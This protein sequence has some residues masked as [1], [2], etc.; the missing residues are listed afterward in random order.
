MCGIVGLFAKTPEVEANLGALLA[1]M[2]HE[3]SD[4]GPDSAGVAFYRNPV[5]AGQTKLTLQHDDSDFD[6][7]VLRSGLQDAMGAEQAVERRGNHA[8]VIAHADL[9][10]VTSFEAVLTDGSDPVAVVVP[11]HRDDGT[12]VLSLPTAATFGFAIAVQNIV[13]GLSQPFIGALADRY[14]A[15]RVSLSLC[16]THRESAPNCSREPLV[17]RVA[18]LSASRPCGRWVNAVNVP[19]S[20]G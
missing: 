19:P 18:W 3:M 9:P 16:S 8:V 1:P 4:R 14:G 13:W 20:P 7:E 17:S 10:V 15:R 6:W 5:A 11:D 12:P 2:L